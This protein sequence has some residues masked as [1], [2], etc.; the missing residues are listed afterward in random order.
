M[1]WLAGASPEERLI[2]L[3]AGTAARRRV[4]WGRAEE[5]GEAVGWSR[6]LG[7]LRERRLLPTLGPRVLELSGEGA[8]ERFAAAAAE[9]VA[10]TRRQAALVQ[11]ISTRVGETL[12][13]EG[14]RSAPLKGPT[15]GEALYGEPGRRPSSDIDLLV[16]AEDLNRAVAVVREM[17]YGAPGDVVR[18][19]S[20]PLLHYALVHER[21]ELPPVELHWRI[22]WYERDFARDRLLPPA[23][24]DAAWRPAPEDELVSLLLY[25]ARDGLTG[26][27]HATDLGAWWDRFGE[28]LSP[29]AFDRALRSYPALQPAA[30]AA[31]RAAEAVV[32]VPAARLTNRVGLGVRGRA[33]VRL[34]NPLPDSGEAQVFAD[35]GL[36]DGLLTPLGGLAGL[37]PAPGRP[38][39]RRLAAERE[40]KAGLEDRSRRPRSRPL[41]ADDRAAAASPPGCAPGPGALSAR[42]F[43]GRRPVLA[44]GRCDRCDPPPAA[45][46]PGP[47]RPAC[48][49]RR[50]SPS[51]PC[52]PS[53]SATCSDCWWPPAGADEAPPRRPP[54]GTGRGCGWRC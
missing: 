35:M 31:S 39:P 34:A 42:T 6:L 46:L 14:I 17:G 51:S 22:H 3:A 45:L 33:A 11:L 52:S 1:R 4:G 5:L 27:R 38:A 36:I 18:D 9:S 21:G 8:D 37:P 20:L 7:T 32:G 2:L 26:L 10:E 29:A 16:A 47:G 49:G 53:R 24:G 54:A 23:A 19:Y 28:E 40:R 25:Y 48:S 50:C 13:A 30:L 12:A 43:R 41:H 15:L 44:L